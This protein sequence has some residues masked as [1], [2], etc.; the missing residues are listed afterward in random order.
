MKIHE[1]KCWPEP[2][3][4]VR[5]GRKKFEIRRNDRDFKR[6]DVVVLREFQPNGRTDE[7]TGAEIF[8]GLTGQVEGPFII[9][10]VE[11][12]AALPEG[13]CGFGLR[14]LETGDAPGVNYPERIAKALDIICT[15]VNQSRGS[16]C[17]DNI[18]D[19]R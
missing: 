4:A 19:E 18:T 13:W 15:A 10:Y 16:I 17:V 14:R 8:Q 2:F 5:Q 9:G 1:L 3:L 12:S 11:Q 6:G 7:E